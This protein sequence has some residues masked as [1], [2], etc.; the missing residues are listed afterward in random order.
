M[1]PVLPQIANKVLTLS[2]TP[3]QRD[4]VQ[5]YLDKMS[6]EQQQQYLQTQQHVLTRIQK[7]Q[8]L[9]AQIRAQVEAQKK[10]AA[11]SGGN[12]SAASAGAGGL[13]TPLASQSVKDAQPVG[14][15]TQQTFLQK[16]RL[17]I[18]ILQTYVFNI[19]KI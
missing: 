3:A 5:S 16:V 15:N 18:N 10:Q 7:Q 14:N 2:L 13:S 17:I 6:P 12:V 1:Y 11:M 19:A 8:Q 9:N 4:K